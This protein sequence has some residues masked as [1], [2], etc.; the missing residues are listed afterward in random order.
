MLHVRKEAIRVVMCVT[1]LLAIV[2]G[3]A[4][5]KP[6]QSN[7]V[8]SSQAT[9]AELPAP[10]KTILMFDADASQPYEVLGEVEATLT[11]QRVYNYEGSRDQVREHLKRVAYAK[12]GDGLDAII[13][14]RVATVVGGGGFWG[15]V[16]AAYGAR[17]T[18]VKS[19]GVAVR[20]KSSTAPLAASAPTNISPAPTPTPTLRPAESA[21]AV[22]PAIAT[23]AAPVPSQPA[24][25]LS[26]SELIRAVQTAL[27]AAGLLSAQPTGTLGPQ[28][29]A[30]ILR[31]QRENSLSADGLA[32]QEL[33]NHL[34]RGK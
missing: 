15:T 25:K 6:A 30:A 2:S 28:T 32:S 16:G 22:A 11:D 12:Y 18:D 27:K 34:T 4:S 17:N 8:P 29:K 3:C 14:Y 21:P 20:F 31:Y 33:L 5:N 23:L 10:K 19:T 24:P 7:A 26:H 13:N 9:A 1:S